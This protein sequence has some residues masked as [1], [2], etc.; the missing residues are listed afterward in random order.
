LTSSQAA[1]GLLHQRQL[2]I[3][4]VGGRVVD[5]LLGLLV[6]AGFGE[7]HVGY[8]GL[9]VAVI[10]REPCRLHLHHDAV[11]GPEYVVRGGQIEL[12]RQGRVGLDRLGDG[13]AFAI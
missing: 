3:A 5:A 9:R 4:G 1:A 2:D 7:H 6:I 11:A 10:E 12:I 13:E 8:E